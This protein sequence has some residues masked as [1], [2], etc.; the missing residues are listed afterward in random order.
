MSALKPNSHVHLSISTINMQ[1]TKNTNM[2]SDSLLVIIK[3]KNKLIRKKSKQIL[4]RNRIC[5]GFLSSLYVAQRKRYECLYSSKFFR[6]VLLPLY[7]Y[8]FIENQHSNAKRIPDEKKGNKTR[9]IPRVCCERSL[10]IVE[11]YYVSADELYVES[12]NR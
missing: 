4:L 2:T 10:T 1:P 8:R 6:E 9:E 3:T 12:E 7:S 5:R 11:T